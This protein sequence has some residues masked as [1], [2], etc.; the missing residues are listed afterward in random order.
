[1]ITI[2][3]ESIREKDMILIGVVEGR[4]VQTMPAVNETGSMLDTASGWNSKDDDALAK[5]KEM[6]ANAR[7]MAKKKM[8]EEAEAMG[9]DA[10]VCLRYSS[11][12]SKDTTNDKHKAAEI[13]AYGTAVK[14]RKKE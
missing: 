2:T 9:A 10:I 4:F 1:M 5:H 3:N 13:T 14:Y 8:I 12:P 7:D 6:M 11:A